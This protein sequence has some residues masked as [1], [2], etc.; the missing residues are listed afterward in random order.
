[1]SD[2]KTVEA[3]H[4]L[5]RACA[6]ASAVLEESR[7]KFPDAPEAV[8]VAGELDRFLTWSRDEQENTPEHVRDQRTYLARWSQQLAGVD[9]RDAHVVVPVVVRALESSRSRNAR[10]AALKRLCSWL[11]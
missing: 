2:N 6:R 5:Q 3:L 11:C 9:L 4:E 7:L 8:H 1:M 10:L